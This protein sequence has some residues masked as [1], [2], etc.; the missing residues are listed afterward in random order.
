MKT[1]FRHTAWQAILGI[2]AAAM[3]TPGHAAEL[4]PGG[5][6]MFTTSDLTYYVGENSRGATVETVPVAGRNFPTAQRI[7]L[8]E[9]TANA[10]VAG[11]RAMLTAELAQDDV[12]VVTFEARALPLAGQP[13]G[14]AKA[15][16]KIFFEERTEPYTKSVELTFQATAEWQVFYLPFR[17]P[18]TLPNGGGAIVFHLG[19]QPQALEIGPVRSLNYG[20]TMQQKDLP[21]TKITYV[22]REA[23]APW[24]AEA[25]A[26]IERIRMAPLIVNVKNATGDP[27]EGAKVEVKQLRN[28]FGFG[29]A[30]VANWL[31]K[32][33]PDGDNY[34][35]IVDECFSRVVFENDLKMEPWEYSLKNDEGA[36]FRWDDTKKAAAWL[37]QRDLPVRGHYLSWAPW[38]PWSEPLRGQPEK[39]KAR[40]LTHIPKV[41]ASV[42]DMV[43]EWDV[44]NHLS[45]W[46]KNIDEVTG[47]EFYTEIMKTA[48]AATTLPLWVNEDQVFRLGRQQEEY[49]TRIQRLIAAGMKPDGIGNQAHFDDSY[50]PSPEE[51]LAV[52][53]RFAALVPALSITE[54]DVVTNGD[55]EL[56]ADYLRDILTVCYSHPAYTGFLTW[57]FWEGMHWKPQTAMWRQD[58]S[59]KPSAKVWRELVTKQ[60][61]THTTGT[62]SQAG[63]FSPAA[64]LGTYEIT[65]TTA[66][67]TITTRTTLSKDSPPILVNVP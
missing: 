7:T 38:E 16:G 32:E 66:G 29:S 6:E 60:W 17:A 23:S 43:F 49:F 25:A 59:E 28:A 34:R 61:S 58:W 44:I 36:F 42:G 62:T 48:R 52:S 19:G 21:R 39:I 55:E 13:A 12:G 22:G 10:W 65:V 26:R 41:L 63:F 30:V 1:H 54:F 20:Q 18:K 11:G 46:D 2:F 4:P 33:G 47:L 31:V 24:R 5:Q 27:V 3:I 67:K 53:D 14:D 35:K 9:S 57:G 40:I 45:G 56:E 8:P 64:H 50:L 15:A 51:M 37:K